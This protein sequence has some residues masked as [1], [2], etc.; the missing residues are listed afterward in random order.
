MD[1]SH[2]LPHTPQV[3]LVLFVDS[4]GDPGEVNGGVGWGEVGLEFGFDFVG[5]VGAEGFAG[6]GFLG[7]GA[8]DGC[9]IRTVA[10]EVVEVLAFERSDEGLEFGADFSHVDDH[11]IADLASDGDFE[12]PVVEMGFLIVGKRVRGSKHQFQNK[13]GVLHDNRFT[14]K[15]SSLNESSSILAKNLT[16][17]AFQI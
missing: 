16:H 4:H 12:G 5:E 13:F 3:G 2:P 1:A 17:S 9:A 11:S 6:R 10:T 7:G 15:V 8:E 14:F